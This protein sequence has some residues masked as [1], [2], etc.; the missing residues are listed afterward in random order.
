M[1]RMSTPP[2]ASLSGKYSSI[3]ASSFLQARTRIVW[4]SRPTASADG[5]HAGDNTALKVASFRR[6]F[7]RDKAVASS[8]HVVGDP[9]PG[10]VVGRFQI[11]RI[12]LCGAGDGER[13]IFQ[14]GFAAAV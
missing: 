11:G 4:P 9:V 10:I 5:V 2:T 8:L 3:T 6:P 14:V 1:L 12:V 7:D 13:H